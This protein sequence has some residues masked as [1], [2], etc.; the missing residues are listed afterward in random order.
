MIF[1]LENGLQG[2][3]LS[4]A[5]G[6]RLLVGPAS[7]V[8]FRTKPIGKDVEIV[9]A[10]SCFDCHDNGMIEK[11]DQIRDRLLASQRF[12][13]DE[14]EILL[15]MY[16]DN[17]T[18]SEYYTQDRE[19]FL[20]ALKDLNAT[21]ETAAGRLASLR[22]P[23]SVGG[24]EIV[25]YLADM[26]F[27]ALDF[28]QLARDFH[29]DIETFKERARRLGDPTL[30]VVVGDWISRLETGGKIQRSEVEKYY[31]D[32]L[33]R[34]SDLRPF[35]YDHDAGY[36]V[37]KHEPEVYDEGA[38]EEE[39]EKAV[40]KVVKKEEEPYEPAVK[41]PV[42]YD[43]PSYEPDHDRLK[44]AIYVDRNEYYVNDLLTFEIEASDRCELQMFYVE[45]SKNIEELPPQLLGPAFLEPG[46]KRRIPYEG[47]GLQ[48][49]FDEPGAGE[50]MLA[51]CRK[52]GLEDYGMSAEGAL[53]Y[54][55]KHFQP[56]TRGIAIE[57][58]D[59]VAEDDG[60]SATNHVTFNVLK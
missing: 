50:T 44:L 41:E 53:D 15:E 45:E 24:G 34:I 37:V 26:H 48:I 57:A 39:V 8:S 14:L 47:S 16:V 36:E 28:E 2:Y 55:K 58:A 43:P 25:T 46:E 19:T 52:G 12:S 9:N 17:D 30:T 21:N 13:R 6:N 59:K 51:F 23:A 32:I 31:G 1:S 11:K 10:R 3:Y 7:I 60:A 20:S 42:E 22:A 5:R 33:E 56:L 27:H 54:A 29:M 18:L 38:Y 40:K 35:R 49:R 4:D